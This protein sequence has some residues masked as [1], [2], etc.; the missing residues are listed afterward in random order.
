MRVPL[1]TALEELADPDHTLALVDGHLEL[2]AEVLAARVPVELEPSDTDGAID[3]RALPIARAALTGIACQADRLRIDTICLARPAVPPGPG[4][5]ELR[6]RL[7]R[8]GRPGARLA[9]DARLLHELAHALGAT[10]HQI[11]IEARGP[12]APLVVRPLLHRDGR[13]GLLM[14]VR[15]PSKPRTRR[16]QRT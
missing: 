15:L 16:E 1:S 13:E 4:Y 7:L 12:R 10:D 6:G 3:P 14:P 5:L 11:E 8:S 2:L 9:L